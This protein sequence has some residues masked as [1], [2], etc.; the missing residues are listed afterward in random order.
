MR[1]ALYAVL[2][3]TLIGLM[4]MLALLPDSM[5]LVIFGR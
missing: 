2:V 5:L 1:E 4:F 3:A